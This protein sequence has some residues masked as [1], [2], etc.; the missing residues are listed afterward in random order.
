LAPAVRTYEFAL[1]DTTTIVLPQ[2][3]V[4]VVA[5]RVRPKN[6]AGA[7]DRRHVVRRCRDGRARPHGVQFTL[8]AYL[9]AT[10]EDVSIVL[11]TPSGMA[12]SGSTVRRSRFG[13]ARRGSSLPVRGIVRG[14]WEIDNYVFNVAS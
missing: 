11:T 2:R 5:L 9:D 1:S 13:A 8:A 3:A 7:G 4:R 14:R 6:M 10:L 12:G